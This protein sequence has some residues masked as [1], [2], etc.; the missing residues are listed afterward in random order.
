M[1][2]FSSWKFNWKVFTCVLLWKSAIGNTVEI[3]ACYN[4]KTTRVACMKEMQSMYGW[5]LM[6]TTEVYMLGVLLLIAKNTDIFHSL[7]RC[8]SHLTMDVLKQNLMERNTC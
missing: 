6:N 3:K 4:R 2:P 8:S 1:L 5:R 7:H